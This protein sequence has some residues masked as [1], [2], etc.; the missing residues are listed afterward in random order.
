MYASALK[1][2][3]PLKLRPP[4]NAIAFFLFLSVWRQFFFFFLLPSDFWSFLMWKLLNLIL[5]FGGGGACVVV[6]FSRSI[7]IGRSDAQ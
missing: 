5:A 6:D 2:D 1:K 7:L 3:L 4:T